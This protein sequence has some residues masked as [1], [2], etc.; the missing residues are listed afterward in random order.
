MSNVICLSNKMQSH[1]KF[2]RYETFINVYIKF[3]YIIEVYQVY[4]PYNLPALK[5]PCKY[6]IYRALYFILRSRADSNYL[7]LLYIFL[8]KMPL[9]CLLKAFW[10]LWLYSLIIIYINLLSTL[11]STKINLLHLQ[12]LQIL[13]EWQQLNL[14]KDLIL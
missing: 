11:L 13:H 1:I 3:N 10:M 14:F 4:L 6:L 9:S 7:I 2:F 8:I 12:Y 5:K